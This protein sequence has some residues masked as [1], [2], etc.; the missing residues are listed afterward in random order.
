MAN[1]EGAMAEFGAHV[2][3]S[4]ELAE[5]Y[6]ANATNVT[7]PT[8]QEV[9]ETLQTQFQVQESYAYSP[10]TLEMEIVGYSSFLQRHQLRDNIGSDDEPKTPVFYVSALL[11]DSDNK[12]SSKVV[13]WCEGKYTTNITPRSQGVGTTGGNTQ[14]SV[15]I[16]KAGMWYDAEATR[17]AA[18]SMTAIAGTTGDG[19][20]NPDDCD[21]YVDY[22]TGTLIVG[23]ENITE[24][25]DA[26]LGI[27]GAVTAG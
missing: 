4:G 14:V 27:P 8:P 2:V 23:G 20:K 1:L 21:W 12:K 13:F 15:T 22:G 3:G 7:F 10:I 17:T 19:P 26:L 24:S 18:D 25:I 11:R 5:S 6:V 16:N 9:R